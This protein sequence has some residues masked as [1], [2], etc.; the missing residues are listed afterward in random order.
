MNDLF[1]YNYFSNG[2]IV[3]GAK[4]GRQ[5]GFPTLNVPWEPECRP[6]FGVYYVRFRAGTDRAWQYGVANYGVKPTVAEADQ[7]PALEVH[8]LTD[9]TLDQGDVIE[10]EWLR[11]VRP[12]QKFES[13]DALKAQI[14]KDRALARQWSVEV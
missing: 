11:F 13:L 3:G 14:A 7:T 4:L 5:I 8:A 10:V 1:G 12:E 2:T 6:C 9:T